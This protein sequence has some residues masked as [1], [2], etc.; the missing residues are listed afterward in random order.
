MPINTPVNQIRLT[1]VALVRLKKG[2]KRFEIACYKNKVTSWR[3]KVETDLDEVIQIDTIFYNVSKGEVAKQAEL[4]KCFKTDDNHKI[5]LEILEKGQL[6]VSER[7]RGHNLENEYRDIATT[8]AEM[9]VNP[10]TNRPYPY[11][12]IEA[13][14]K[15]A[16]YNCKPNRSSKQQALDVIRILQE[17]IPI[18]RA[19]MRVRVFL[20][21]NCAKTAKPNIITLVSKVQEENWDNGEYDM[22]GLIQPGNYRP[23]IESISKETKGKGNL[24]LLSLKEVHEGDEMLE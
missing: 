5:L 11:T 20:P 18:E 17:A 2:G 23:L 21:Q 22:I 7:E 24:E 6:Q 16:H 1:N 19:Q 15:E 4:R 12:V 8:V 3:Q 13:S 9:C 10:E 14:M